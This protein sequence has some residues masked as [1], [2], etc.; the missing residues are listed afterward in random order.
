VSIGEFGGMMEE[1]FDS[2]R[3]AKF[4]W[5]RWQTL[6]GTRTA[7]FSYR[8]AP[9]FSQYSVGCRTVAQLG[10]KRRQEYVK[11]GTGD[12]LCRSSIWRGNAPD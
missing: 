7:V 11:R 3:A 1:I 12:R 10:G 4:D 5:D 9:E 2:S 6:E 8:V